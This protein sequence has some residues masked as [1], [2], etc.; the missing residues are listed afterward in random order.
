MAPDEFLNFSM[1]WPDI[2]IKEP[3]CEPAINIL[4]VFAATCPGA[5]TFDASTGLSSSCIYTLDDEKERHIKKEQK[6][7]F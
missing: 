4:I 7:N 6:G 2:P 5:T 1:F 3:A